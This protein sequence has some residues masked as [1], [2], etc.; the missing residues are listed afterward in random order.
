M[1]TKLAGTKYTLSDDFSVNRSV[2]SVASP[3]S[4]RAFGAKGDG[5]TD[6]TAAIN[7]ALAYLATVGGGTLYFPQGSYKT[8]AEIVFPSSSIHLLG[9]GRRK[10]YP[11]LF[12]PSGN[13]L[14]TIFGVHA[15][16]NLFKISS[17]T[18]DIRS[19]I[20]ATEINFATLETGDQPTAAF[21]FECGDFQRDFTFNRCGI[22][23][24]TS[25][26]DVYD[27][28]GSSNLQMGVFKAINC[29]I[30]RNSWIA[31]NLNSTQWNGFVFEK[32]EAG[33]NGFGVG[34]GGIDIR[35][36]ACSIKDNLLEGQ[37]NPI[38][39]TGL[40]SPAWV[41]GNYFEETVGFANVYISECRGPI[42]VLG[43]FHLNTTNLVT[44]RVF[45]DRT[46]FFNTDGPY[47]ASGA[48]KSTFPKFSTPNSSPNGLG[49]V[50]A[51]YSSTTKFVRVD[52]VN[53]VPAMALS[54][55][56]I[57]FSAI[58]RP[59]G[60]RE[61][62]PLTGNPMQF[63]AFSS[64]GALATNRQTFSAS[65]TASVGDWIIA[66][67]LV[68]LDSEVEPPYVSWSGLSDGTQDFVFDN[69]ISAGNIG[70]WCVVTVGYRT[71]ATVSG[72]ISV[73][74]YPYG[75]G[76]IAGKT[77]ALG[78]MT[79]S[80][81][82]SIEKAAPFVYATRIEQ[83][84]AAPTTGTWVVGDKIWSSAPTA[85]N[86]PGWVCVAGGAPGTWQ[87]MANLA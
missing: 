13:T 32:N 65:V 75:T 43:N 82:D 44:H 21:G 10:C 78:G 48:Y 70:E 52:S 31:R 87:A 58:T 79:F 61:I 47:W 55:G 14:S 51:L 8:T 38:K 15:G 22:H 5:V 45:V 60:R 73:L 71:T 28:T 42:N 41:C 81:V 53:D 39:L 40:Y 64:G 18:L 85:G 33:Q 16:R 6:D 83:A 57:K 20:N 49:D 86:P 50:G 34:T 59:S 77:A 23:G 54:F 7:S 25:A 17:D 26:F 30:N 76:A 4:V 3:V 74:F 56:A 66:S 35:A 19:N 63:A 46:A 67:F 72:S 37:R 12:V 2:V 62:N 29:S 36:H 11:G 9:N 69:F 27:G 1:P 84:A 24:F 80:V 68:K